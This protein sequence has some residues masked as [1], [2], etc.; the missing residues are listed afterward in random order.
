MEHNHTKN[1]ELQIKVFLK[2][3]DKVWLHQRPAFKRK[4]FG[5]IHTALSTNLD[6]NLVLFN[7]KNALVFKLATGKRYEEDCPTVSL[8]DESSFVINRKLNV[9][10]LFMVDKMCYVLFNRLEERKV[11]SS[12]VKGMDSGSNGLGMINLDEID[13]TF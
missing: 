9:Q 13:K 12:L 8:E 2:I 1:N 5:L 7:Q 10:S 6:E 11:N 3:I 4:D